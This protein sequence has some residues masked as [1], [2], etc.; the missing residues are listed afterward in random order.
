M[1]KIILHFILICIVV[2]LPVIIFEYMS[3]HEYHDFAFIGG[4]TYFIYALYWILKI[5]NHTAK[6]IF[7]SILQFLFIM[8]VGLFFIEVENFE[9]TSPVLLAINLMIYPY[10]LIKN[11]RSKDK[12]KWKAFLLSF[13]II[14]I[15][16]L[17]GSLFWFYVLAMSGMQ[18]MRY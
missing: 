7:G 4:I 8:V 9:F 14:F 17:L 2:I 18:N 11:P 6:I 12:K 13:I 5:K 3:N 16:S 15:L 10:L 1:K